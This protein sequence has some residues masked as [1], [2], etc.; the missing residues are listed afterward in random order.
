[1]RPP[2]RLVAGAAGR[3]AGGRLQDPSRHRPRAD[4]G[5]QPGLPWRGRRRPALRTTCASAMGRPAPRR[6]VQTGQRVRRPGRADERRDRP[7]SRR[8]VRLHL[9]PVRPGQPGRH[10]PQGP[11][12]RLGRR[13]TR[14]PPE[15]VEHRP[16]ARRPGRGGLRAARGRRAPR[17]GLAAG[18]RRRPRRPR[19]RA[20]RWTCR[21]SSRRSSTRPRSRS[22]RDMSGVYLVDLEHGDAVATAGYNVPESWIG[23]R[24]AP[25]AGR[26]R[27][28]RWRPARRS[29]PTTTSSSPASSS[30]PVVGELLCRGVGA[31]RPGTTSC[32]AR[33]RSAWTTRRH[34]HDEDLRTLE[35]IAGLGDRRVPQRGGLR[36]RPA[37]RPHRRA[38]RR[39]QPRRDAAAHPRGDRPRAPRRA[40]A[41]RRDPRPR[42]LQGRQRHPGPRGRRRAAAQ[43]RP[44]AAGRAARRT[45]RSPATAA[46]SS[47]CCSPAPTRRPPRRSPSAA[48][49]RSAASARSASPPGTTGSTPTGCSS[50]PTA[51]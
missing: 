51:R 42:R 39:A 46:T 40:S 16:A 41:R 35:A 26:R 15:D 32:A 50:R 24:V 36:A 4:A 7:R 17:R 14:S 25:G 5:G 1:M 47:C 31:D 8:A 49:T 21:R 43:G 48:G 27:A 37:R 34:V 29:S 30:H 11:V 20:R 10:G 3:C 23:V 19:A 44:R 45:T 28:R 22:T 2:R 18:P 33:S 13:A 38:D 6:V 12:R 9:R